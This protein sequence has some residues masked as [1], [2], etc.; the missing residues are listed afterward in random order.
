VSSARAWADRLV[1]GRPA[2]A[3][4]PQ[5]QPQQRPQTLPPPKNKMPTSRRVSWLVG[6][7]TRAICC[8]IDSFS[9][10]R[11]PQQHV[12]QVLASAPLRGL[13]SGSASTLEKILRRP[14]RSSGCTRTS[15]SRGSWR[16][17]S[18][19]TGGRW[20]ARGR[21]RS[22][23]MRCP[24]PMPRPLSRRVW[25]FWQRCMQRWFSCACNCRR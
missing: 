14:P 21:R 16:T 1:A 17:A 15:T 7:S 23:S 4:Q 24:P 9:A 6:V 11:G 5:Q 19:Q 12:Q 8:L 20:G 25:G 22:G 13:P 2:G 3:W 10:E 18:G